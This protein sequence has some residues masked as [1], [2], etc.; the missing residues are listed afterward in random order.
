MDLRMQIADLEEIIKGKNLKVTE[1]K[2][3]DKELWERLDKAKK[4]TRKYKD[5]VE[6]LEFEIERL[7]TRKAAIK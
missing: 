7:K 2:H 4:K 5:M 1:R 3:E 6:K